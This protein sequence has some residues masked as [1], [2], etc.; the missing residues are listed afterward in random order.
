M[1]PENGYVDQN[2]DALNLSI[3]RGSLN[4]Q[5][6]SCLDA[7]KFNHGNLAVIGTVIGA[8]H[9][10]SVYV[11]GAETCHEVLACVQPDPDTNVELSAPL[12]LVPPGRKTV[13]GG[14]EHSFAYTVLDWNVQAIEAVRQ[15][16]DARH[17]ET[18][19]CASFDFPKADA[20]AHTPKTIVLI[21]QWSDETV[22]VATLHSYPGDGVVISNT[23]LKEGM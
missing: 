3:V 10:L 9:V 19:A 2:P 14:I 5:Q 17:A 6:F 13:I 23:T 4:L 22:K 21:R 18:W 15:F 12:H 8:S 20:S 7:V 11:D 16:D 1:C